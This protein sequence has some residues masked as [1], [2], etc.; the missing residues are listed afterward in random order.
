MLG[1]QMMVIDGLV[2]IMNDFNLKSGFKAE[3]R[4]DKNIFRVLDCK[5]PTCHELAWS[6]AGASPF[7][8]C[9]DCVKHFDA[10]RRGLRDAGAAFDDTKTFARGLDY[11]TQTIFE[12]RAKGLGAQ[13]A[14]AAG[15]RYNHLVEELGGSPMGA[16]GWAAGIERILLAQQSPSTAPAD[17]LKRQGVYLAV[18]QSELIGQGFRQVQRLREQGV[19]ALMDYDGKSLKAQLREADKAG[20]Q[21]VAILGEAELKQGTITLKD[22]D[23]KSQESVPLDQFAGTVAQR[24]N[25]AC[26]HR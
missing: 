12:V 14:I 2:G 25:L 19:Q 1:P 20:C 17:G 24:M 6:A 13:D 8:L 3:K 16:V 11:Y 15:G 26:A 9:D 22:L 21:Y 5:N 18:A 4:F 7:L 23:G 10:V